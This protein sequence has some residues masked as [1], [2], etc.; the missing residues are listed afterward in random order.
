MFLVLLEGG[1]LFCLM[2]YD[3]EGLDVFCSCFYGEDFG[4]EF[5]EF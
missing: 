3:I 4:E 2:L 5:F 1:V